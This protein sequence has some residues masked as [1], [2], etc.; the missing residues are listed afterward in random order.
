MINL[1]EN[2]IKQFRLDLEK[3]EKIE[4]REWNHSLIYL[5]QKGRGESHLSDLTCSIKSFK[6]AAVSDIFLSFLIAL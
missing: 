4:W 5:D 6:Y 2:E 1:M 3:V